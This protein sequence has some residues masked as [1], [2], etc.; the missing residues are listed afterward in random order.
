MSRYAVV[1]GGM[2]GMAVTWMLSRLGHDVELLERDAQLG[3]RS[4]SAALGERSVTLGGKNIGQR[5][6]LFREFT[7]AHGD[8][9]YEPFGINASPV[10]DGRVRTFDSSRRL[11][12]FARFA[13]DMRPRDAIRLV[14]LASRTLAN[15]DNRYLGSRYFARLGRRHD[16][17]PAGAYFSASFARSVLR[18]MTVRMNGAEPDEVWLGNLGANLGML[19]DSY[20]QLVNGTEP[21]VSEFRARHRVRTGVEVESIAFD[22]DGT[23]RG[24]E[25]RTGDG[26]C[27]TI[28]YD[29]V[30]LAIP[31][32]AAARLVRE[33]N[34][35]LA[36]K[37]ESV[38][39]H[40]GAVVI[41]EYDRELFSPQVRGLAFEAGM[42][43][44][45][46]GA[47]GVDERHIARYTFSGRAAR[48]H[49]G[50]AFEPEALLDVAERQVAPHLPVQDARRRGFV[51]RRWS[52]AYCAYVPDHASF[53]T[54]VGFLLGRNAGLHLT[55][56]YLRGVS[57]EACFRAARDCAERIGSATAAVREVGVGVPA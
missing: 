43:L 15:E 35:P 53:R 21:L 38:R 52:A 45:N 49:V 47:Y 25:A 54:A 10:V 1:G 41:C 46:A 44:S 8:H 30:V 20:D 6:T 32:A 55:G 13:E 36:A 2:S 31:A 57:I 29:G 39:Y 56:D 26:R 40:P 14:T 4:Q 3:G 11:R 5:Y 12:S 16:H 9:A 19:F 17:R 33:L 27:E 51:A 18:P 22:A 28:A 23:V 7:A 50:A 34:A 48:E 24:V 42:P 37:L